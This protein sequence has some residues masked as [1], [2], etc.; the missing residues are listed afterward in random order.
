MSLYRT[1]EGDVVDQICFRIY[2]TSSGT[3]EAL[4]EANPGLAD[5]GATLP[6][7]LEL[8][9]PPPPQTP[10]RRAIRLWD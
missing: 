1:I 6:A 4:L 9:L 3:T 10:V 5:R 8:V 2:G 7:G